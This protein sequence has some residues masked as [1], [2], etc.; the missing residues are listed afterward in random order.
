[1]GNGLLYNVYLNNGLCS[2]RS[3]SSSSVYW[4]LI[5]PSV[6]ASRRLLALERIHQ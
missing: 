6:I 3:M 5:S 2:P 4:A 1:M